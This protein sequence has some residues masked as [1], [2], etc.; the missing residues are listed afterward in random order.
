[1]TD[2]LT[3]TLIVCLSLMTR[4]LVLAAR[5]EVRKSDAEAACAQFWLERERGAKPEA[6]PE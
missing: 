4:H 1:M 5:A 3:A 2:V 6:K